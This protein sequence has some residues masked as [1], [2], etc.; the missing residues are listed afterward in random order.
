MVGER[1]PPGVEHGGETDPGTEMLRVGRDREERVSGRP[2]QQVVDHGLVLERRGGDRGR[3]R[4]DDVIVRHRQQVGLPLFQPGPRGLALALGAM[5]VAAG[6]VGDPDV[7]AALA[8][9][10]MAAERRRATRSDRRHDLELAA[11]QVPAMARDIR[12]AM[13]SEDIRD[14]Q[15][16]PRHERRGFYGC[17]GGA[18]SAS[19]LVTSRIAF[20][21]TRV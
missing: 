4:E 13:G 14:L 5:A 16:R 11:A 19:G 9:C 12:V 1:R 8:A 18:S 15:V 2:E 10:D 7:V 3:E 17:G 21:A 6:V 20:R